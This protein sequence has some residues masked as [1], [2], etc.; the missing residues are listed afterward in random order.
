MATKIKLLQQIHQLASSVIFKHSMLVV[1]ASAGG[2]VTDIR[3]YRV[4]CEFEVQA[5]KNDK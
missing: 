5:C 4:A 1:W 2:N 3:T